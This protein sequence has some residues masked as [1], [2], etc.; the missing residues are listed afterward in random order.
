[1]SSFFCPAKVEKPPTEADADYAILNNPD[2][3]NVQIVIPVPLTEREESIINNDLS[4]LSTWILAGVYP[5]WI[6]AFAGMTGR[7]RDDISG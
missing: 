6:P 4:D 1:L 2:V 3:L 7:G 5:F